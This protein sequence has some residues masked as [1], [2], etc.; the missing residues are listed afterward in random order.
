ML[1]DKI[2]G[3]R[4]GLF[5][6]R[7]RT[8]KISTANSVTAIKK[9]ID[10]TVQEN[11]NKE[12][13]ILFTNQNQYLKSKVQNCYSLEDFQKVSSAHTQ[14]N[15]RLMIVSKP[16]YFATNYCLVKVAFYRNVEHNSGSYFLFEKINGIWT[17]KE[18]LNE[19]N[20]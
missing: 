3:I 12:F 8:L 20:T 5:H 6:S 7:R 15:Q 4:L 19:W 14:N 2:L 11:W 16:I 18:T 17:I 1:I 13:E 9:Q 10:I